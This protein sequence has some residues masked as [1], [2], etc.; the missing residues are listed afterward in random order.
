MY[1]LRE[2]GNPLW[3]SEAFYL[4]GITTQLDLGSNMG[5]SLTGLPPGRIT[6]IEAYE[7]AVVHLRQ[8]GLTAIHG[9]VIEET[10]HLLLDENKKFDCVTLFDLIE[11]LPKLKGSTLLSNI[12]G[13]A[14]RQIIIFVPAESEELQQSEEYKKFIESIPVPEDQKELQAH[15][16]IW[17]QEDFKKRGYGIVSIPNFH[18]PGFGAFFAI[19]CVNPQDMEEIKI[20]VG[21]LIQFLSFKHFG[22]QSRIIPPVER[23][24]NNKYMSIGDGVYIGAY[25]RLECIDDYRGYKYT[26]NLI[27]GN[28]VSIEPFC[29]LGCA[30]TLIIE[31]DVMIAGHVG[32]WDH[33]H[34]WKD[35]DTPPKYQP[36]IPLP[37][38]ICK[39]SW[40]G[41]N[42]VVSGGVTVGPHA[43]VSANSLVTSNLPGWSKASGNP[44]QVIMRYDFIDRSWYNSRQAQGQAATTIIIPTHSNVVWLEQC[45][46]SIKNT[47]N[48]SLTEI[49]VIENGATEEVEKVLDGLEWIKVLH[50]D[51]NVGYIRAINK[52]IVEANNPYVIIMNDDVLVTYGWLDELF[53]T[54]R[55]NPDVGLVGPITNAGN[56]IQTIPISYSKIEDFPNFAR[57]TLGKNI[58]VSYSVPRITGFCTL[59][60]PKL[61]EEIGG[62]DPRFGIGNYDDDDFCNRAKLSGYDIRVC[63]SAFVHHA[64]HV[65]FS[66]TMNN[67]EF[68]ELLETNWGI[69]KEK[70]RL[71]SGL[72]RGDPYE[73]TRLLNLYVDPNL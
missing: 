9:D 41:E 63:M 7:P 27:I 30:G 15:K 73:M 2:L 53:N 16:S 68:N 32:V 5:A 42:V 26:P 52:G 43:V 31:D 65:T 50:N 1:R 34:G 28:N 3:M 47:T 29:H 10:T 24:V 38:R 18:Y 25:S 55:S 60:S 20:K 37:T 4:N 36:L 33:I 39:G 70:W 67:E 66:Q 23:I 6:C 12:E 14:T 44:A 17:T 46:K 8:Q 59:I 71:D 11:H 64:S 19:K 56:G 45:L 69:F 49:L 61:I 21:A 54:M 51:T 13:I 62:L 57:K 40:I 35:V 48:P 58:E 72:K 22:K